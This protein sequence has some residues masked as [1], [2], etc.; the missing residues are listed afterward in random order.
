MKTKEQIKKKLKTLENQYSQLEKRFEK[1]EAESGEEGI[2]ED[3]Y[4]EYMDARAR[5]KSK[6]NL[7]KWI[8]KS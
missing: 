4:N 8:L 2:Y 7:I 6:T 1:L 5:L 3:E